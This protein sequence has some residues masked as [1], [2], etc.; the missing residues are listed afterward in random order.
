MR[1]ADSQLLRPNVYRFVKAFLERAGVEFGA[2]PGPSLQPE[3]RLGSGSGSAVAGEAD[4]GERRP[5][6]TCLISMEPMD[7]RGDVPSQQCSNCD[8]SLARCWC[9]DCNEA[10]CDDCVSAH[11]RVSLTR[12]HRLQNQASDDSGFVSPT[13]FCK[14]H[15][16]ETLKL[17]CVTCVQLTCRD[18]QLESHKNHSFRFISGAMDGVLLLMKKQLDVYLQLLAERMEA[19]AKSLQDMETR[20]KLLTRFVYIQAA[21]LQR[22]FKIMF[23]FLK[24]RI[25]FLLKEIQ[26]A[27]KSERELINGRMLAVQRLQESHKSLRE[28]TEKAR[29]S[30]DPLVLMSHIE[31]MKSQMKDLVDQDSSPPQNM[32]SVIVVTDNKF[33]EGLLNFGEIKVSWVPFSVSETLLEGMKKLPA[34]SVSSPLT[35]APPTS[36]SSQP[37]SCNKTNSNRVFSPVSSGTSSTN[38]SSSNQSESSSKTSP[39][40]GTSPGAVPPVPPLSSLSNISSPLTDSDPSTG[41]NPV[42]QVPPA[43]S[44]SSLAHTQPRTTTAAGINTPDP[45][46]ILSAPSQSTTSPETSEMDPAAILRKFNILTKSQL[47][48]DSG[49]YFFKFRYKMKPA[50]RR[51]SGGQT[52]SVCHKK[53]SSSSS[54]VTP[55]CMVTSSITP[56]T[57]MSRSVILQHIL[58]QNA[59]PAVGRGNFQPVGSSSPSSAGP[60][61]STPARS[62]GTPARSSGTPARSSGTPAWSSGVSVQ[63]PGTPARSLGVSVQ[64]PGTPARSLGVSVQSPGTPARSSGVSVQSPGTTAQSSGFPSQSSWTPAQSSGFPSQSSWTPAQSSGPAVWFDPISPAV[65]FDPIS[66]AVW[67]DP[68]SPAV[69]FDSI[70]P[71]VWFDPISPALSSEPNF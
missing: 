21:D 42:S 51:S 36:S 44:L 66:P 17:F 54:S 16:S 70:S 53:P 11:R 41:K 15:P 6:T 68:I 2:E 43:S 1:A 60:L 40:T 46:D 13:K 57:S 63:S 47:E 33:L 30:T 28:V 48:L 65:W 52:T 50:D 4:N 35:E 25:E 26:K 62:S 20:L 56:P 19:A 39:Q 7:E 14:V 22:V 29:N 58:S 69:W 24:R 31:Q 5:E 71:A 37:P 55:S 32:I 45:S 18:C 27:Y 38:T 12:W 67:F 34:P 8:S 9:L 49:K 3:R 10:L 59:L 23:V 61:L 64:S